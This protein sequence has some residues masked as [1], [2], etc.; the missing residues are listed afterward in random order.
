MVQNGLI[1]QLSESMCVSMQCGTSE[2]QPAEPIA[3]WLFVC[4]A[5]CAV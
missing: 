3:L 1:I 4:E 5:V 2:L